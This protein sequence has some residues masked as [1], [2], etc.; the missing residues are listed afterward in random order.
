[1]AGRPRGAAQRDDSRRLAA[2]HARRAQAGVGARGGGPK[3]RPDS[4]GA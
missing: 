2:E 4:Q 1:M 3:S